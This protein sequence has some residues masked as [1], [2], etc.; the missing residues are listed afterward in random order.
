MR[1]HDINHPIRLYK[2]DACGR[3]GLSSIIHSKYVDYCLECWNREDN[4]EV[5]PVEKGEEKTISIKTPL[6]LADECQDIVHRKK[7]HDIVQSK[8]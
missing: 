2:C 1:Y 3:D 5:V 6:P 7:C 4:V 8:L